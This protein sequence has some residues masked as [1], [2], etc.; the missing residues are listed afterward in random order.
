MEILN[1]GQQEGNYI[2]EAYSDLL[3]F[4][5]FVSL[6]IYILERG[7]EER[8]RYII[9]SCLLQMLQPGIKS[10]TWVYT[11]TGNRIHTFWHMAQYF[12]Q[13]RHTSQG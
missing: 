12:N 5:L 2:L 13:L 11:L 3:G 4:C 10:A 9:D 7:R 6:L 8:E 1:V